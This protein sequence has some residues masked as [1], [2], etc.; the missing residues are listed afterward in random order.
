MVP[1]TYV[2]LCT[3]LVLFRLQLYILST[4]SNLQLECGVDDDVSYNSFTYLD[5]L[6]L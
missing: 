3:L 5:L 4:I 2:Y 1:R 6:T